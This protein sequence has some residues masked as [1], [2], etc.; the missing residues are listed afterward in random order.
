MSQ[1]DI[2]KALQDYTSCDV[3]DAL[4]KLKYRNG[5]FLPGLTLWS[6]QRQDGPTKIVGPAYTVKYVPLDDPAPKHPTHYHATQIDNVP[7][8]A[9]VFVSAPAGTPNAVYGGLMSTQA[10]ALGAVGSV[11]D[12]RFRDVQEQRALGYPVFARD[13]G[14]AP[15]AP[16]LKVA[17]VNVPVRLQQQQQQQ[18]DE[19]DEGMLLTV[20]PG[21]YLIGDA[22]GVVVLPAEVA[23]QALPLMK[24]QVEADEKMAEAIQGVWGSVKLARSS[25]RKSRGGT[26]WKRC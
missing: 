8:G 18:Q 5:G 1:Q 10:R 26:R 13:V 21:D 11:I 17:G 22:N 14:T 2:I 16:L 3:S 15:P 19:G 23:E 12:G 9:V 24:K 6:P 7:A 25:A 20:R 4:C